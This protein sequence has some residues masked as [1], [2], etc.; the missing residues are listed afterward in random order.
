VNTNPG[1]IASSEPSTGLN[2]HFKHKLAFIVFTIRQEERRRI[3]IQKNRSITVC[4]I[5]YNAYIGI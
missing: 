5:D 2:V 4:P 3:K 1:V